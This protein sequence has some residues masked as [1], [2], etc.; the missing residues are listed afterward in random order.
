MTARGTAV[1]SL[2]GDPY[3]GQGYGSDRT[4]EQ[5]RVPLESA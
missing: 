5:H 2:H 3:Q 1:V 4:E